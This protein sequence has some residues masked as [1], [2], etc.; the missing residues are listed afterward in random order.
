VEAGPFRA[1]F[2]GR[3]DERIVVAHRDSP[4]LSVVDSRELAVTGRVYVGSGARALEV[5][6]RSGRIFLAR[7][8]AGR[9][10][11]FDPNSLLPLAEWRVPG[12]VAWLAVE[13]EGN[14]LGV[15]LQDPPGVRLVGILGGEPL[16][17]VPL[18]PGGGALAFVQGGSRP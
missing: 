3:N 17:R 4:Y 2:S 16:A 15:L 10:E 5:D 11:V 1:R 13:S 7:G 12:E 14:H 18:G 8:A 6:P 9:V